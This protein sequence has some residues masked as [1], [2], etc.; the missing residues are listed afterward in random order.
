MV[1]MTYAWMFALQAGLNQGVISSLFN[2]LAIFDLIVFYFAFGETVRKIHLFGVFFMFAGVVCI[3]LASADSDEAD[4]DEDI[5][6]GG[7]S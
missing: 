1:F 3:A 5:D 4:L 7:R 2:L 6:T